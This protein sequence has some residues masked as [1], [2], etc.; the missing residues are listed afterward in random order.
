MNSKPKYLDEDEI[1]AEFIPGGSVGEFIPGWE[2]KTTQMPGK[3]TED[4]VYIGVV[5][6]WGG[7]RRIDKSLRLVNIDYSESNT[8]EGELEEKME[9]YFQ[10]EKFLTREWDPSIA[11]WFNCAV[12]LPEGVTTTLYGYID[13]LVTNWC[14]DDINEVWWDWYQ[15]NF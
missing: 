13:I 11:S 15:E 1:R 3:E 14:Y 5:R 6:I 7:D 9:F 10:G 8:V 12:Q 2:N 4:G